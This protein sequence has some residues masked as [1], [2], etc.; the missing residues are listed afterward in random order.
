MKTRPDRFLSYD[1]IDHNS[2]IF[3]YIQELH[4]YLW[5]VI[6]AVN[7]GASGAIDDHLDQA[8][9]ELEAV[10]VNGN[11][12]D[13]P[14][15]KALID[16]VQ[17]VEWAQGDDP[18]NADYDFCPWCGNWKRNGHLGNCQRQSALAAFEVPE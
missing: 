11:V 13:I 6:R 16:V 10:Y 14:D 1:K 3:H 5:R 7:P 15:V 4:A 17:A 9:D 18:H 8:I 12:T 2:E